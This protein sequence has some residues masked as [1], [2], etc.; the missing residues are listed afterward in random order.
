LLD[1]EKSLQPKVD[2]ETLSSKQQPLDMYA[3]TFTGILTRWNSTHDMLKDSVI[4]NQQFQW[5]YIAEDI[6]FIQ[7]FLQK[8]KGS[9]TAQR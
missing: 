5:C 6:L 3:K 4:N 9:G 1:I 8:N 2:W 7:K